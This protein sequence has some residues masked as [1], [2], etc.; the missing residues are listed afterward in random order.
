ME[1]LDH[2]EQERW[3][4][5][6]QAD[7]ASHDDKMQEKWQMLLST[8]PPMKGK[9]QAQINYANDVR[10]AWFLARI[11]DLNEYDRFVLPGHQPDSSDISEAQWQVCR[12]TL[13]RAVYIIGISSARFWLDA[14]KYAVQKIEP[15]ESFGAWLTEPRAEQMGWDEAML[16]SLSH[17]YALILNQRTRDAF[18]LPL[19]SLTLYF[20]FWHGRQRQIEPV[21]SAWI[22]PDSMYR[23]ITRHWPRPVDYNRY[24]KTKVRVIDALTSLPGLSVEILRHG[25]NLL[26]VRAEDY[27]RD[28]AL[29][30]CDSYILTIETYVRRNLDRICRQSAYSD[31]PSTGEQFADYIEEVRKTVSN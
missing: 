30:I 29:H 20:R 21:D 18:A 10:K 17:A 14:M 8:L 27:I 3:R 5:E 15:F 7:K 24:E 2:A 9:S 23:Y 1:K 25:A 13:L 19:G 28:I 11:N 26:D 12:E 4:A 6:A 16:R 31:N 22:Q